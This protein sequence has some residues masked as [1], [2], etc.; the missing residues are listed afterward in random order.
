M[1][2]NKILSV[3]SIMLVII[4]P[5]GISYGLF[6]IILSF[7]YKSYNSLMLVF[8]IAIIIIINIVFILKS[9]IS[10]KQDSS[11]KYL[12]FTKISLWSNYAFK[13]ISFPIILG[14][15]FLLPIY[16]TLLFEKLP[17]GFSIYSD[18]EKIIFVFI[19]VLILLLLNDILIT[20][21]SSLYWIKSIRNKNNKYFIVYYL[22]YFVPII[23]I[24]MIYKSKLTKG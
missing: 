18:D 3:F 22:L 6:L 9:N 19:L 13:I 17:N 2:V 14:Q 24:V 16:V 1:K 11:K 5:F 12:L 10:E 21:I 15:L 8:G 23:N 20:F 7:L 4:T